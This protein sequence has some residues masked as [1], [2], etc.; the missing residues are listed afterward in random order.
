MP[1]RDGNLAIVVGAGEDMVHITT[2]YWNTESLHRVRLG[3][4]GLTTAIT[5]LEV[6]PHVQ[7][8]I[9]AECMPGDNKTVEYASPWAVSE[10]GIFGLHVCH[11]SRLAISL[12]LL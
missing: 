7:C 3:V 5:L 11:F 4:I 1:T 8:T 9:I 2:C 10:I 6:L 12:V